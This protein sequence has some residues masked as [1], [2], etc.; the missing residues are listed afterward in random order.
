MSNELKIEI[1]PKTNINDTHIKETI[2]QYD[3]FIKE[4]DGIVYKTYPGEHIINQIIDLMQEELSEP[5]PIFTYRYFLNDYP[6]SCLMAYDNGKFVGCIIGKCDK[7]K[8]QKMKGYIAMIAVD[9]QYRGKKIGKRLGELFLHQMK[10][11]YNAHE[12]YL[13]TEVTNK[14]ALG[15]YEGLGFVRTKLNFNYYLNGNSAFRLKL[16]LREFTRD[17]DTLN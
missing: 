14:A 15:L 10:N 11:V 3:L 9:K 2:K 13:E 12:V 1:T 5:Y 8:H 6:D 16:W 17:S 7:T 4:I